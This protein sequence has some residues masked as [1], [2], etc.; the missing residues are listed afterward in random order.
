MRERKLVIVPDALS[1]LLEQPTAEQIVEK[2]LAKPAGVFVTR[3]RVEEILEDMTQTEKAADIVVRAASSFDP[4]AKSIESRFREREEYDVTNKSR[5]TGSVDDFVEHFRDRFNS[6]R[7][8]LKNRQTENAIMTIA[9][10][11]SAVDRRKIRIIGMVKEKRVTKN[12][13]TLIEIEDESSVQACLVSREA[14][15]ALKDVVAQILNDEV[16][17][18]DG[19]MSRDLF[20]IEGV[21]WPE[22]PFRE[23]PLLDVDFNIAFISDTHV[24]SKFF[25]QKQF[26][27]LLN[28]FNGDVDDEAQREAA[29]KIKYLFVAGDLIDGIGIYPSQESE[30]V[31]KDVFTQ[32]EIFAEFI[33][34]VPDYIEVIIGPGNH[35]PV[36]IAQPR[37]RL[38]SEF[39]RDLDKYSN[40]HFVGDP[41]VFEVHGLKALMFHGDSF[42]SVAAAIPTLANA[43]AQP[44]SVGIELLKRRH[45]SP[46]YGEN[47]IVPERR[48]Y[49]FINEVPDILHY[50][51]VHHNG[52]ANYRGTTIINAG[53]WQD[54]TD[55]ALKQG[56]LPTPCQLPI[57][58]VRSGNLS[59]INFKE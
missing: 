49:L 55:Y 23:K 30:L 16:L 42:Y 41:S 56:H 32:F 38:S 7:K 33:K 12:G 29:G 2:I 15:Q 53:T 50:G 46:V 5:C 51:H 28:F 31:T 52:Y 1:F 54:T 59:V 22:A 27:R 4:P 18:F 3:A 17:A 37:P 26:S 20:I 13:H 58:N 39:T 43:H 24:G 40:I 9:G 6:I 14:P 21:T 10:A 25:L 44:E 19:V 34:K 45:L 36:R 11:R 47:P 57:Y 35:D 8:L 48:D